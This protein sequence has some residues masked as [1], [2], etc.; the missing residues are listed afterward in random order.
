MRVSAALTFI[1][2]CGLAFSNAEVSV[3][4]KVNSGLRQK[5][6][7]KLA[8]H[9]ARIVEFQSA[10]ETQFVA[11]ASVAVAPASSNAATL[12]LVG[13]FVLWYG[14]NAGYNVYNAYVKK[15]F[16][17]PFAIATLQLFVGL[18]YA[19]PLW[20]LGVRKMPKLSVE[21]FMRLLPIAMLNAAGHACAVN[22]MFEKGGGSFTH[23]NGSIRR[24]TL[25]LYGALMLA[26][27]FIM[28]Y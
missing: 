25:F 19:V 26:L 10:S 11:A 23:G 12:K 7:G 28:S 22:A 9:E 17:Y 8:K 13:L 4:G 24:F 21:D 27:H 15:D 6:T 14:F 18:F 5:S 20:L 3:V 16:Q 2:A 1:A